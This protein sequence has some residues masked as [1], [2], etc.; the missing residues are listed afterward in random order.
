[1]NVQSLDSKIFSSLLRG[2]AQNLGKHEREVNELNVFPIPDGDTGSNML[3]TVKGGEQTPVG[4]DDDLGVTARRIADGML[5][6]A[7]GNSGVIL[8]QF[9]DGIAAGL[10]GYKV[11]DATILAQAFKKGVEHAYAAVL[12]PT[13]GTILTVAREASAYAADKGQTVPY[14]F[15][16]DFLTQARIT[17]QNTPDML[18]VLKKAGVVD[19]GGAGLIYI[20]EGMANTL[21]GSDNAGEIADYQPVQQHGTIDL[22]RFDENSELTYGYCTEV[23]L[24]LQNAKTDVKNFDEKV[25]KDFLSSVGDSVVC[26][27]SGSVIKLHVHTTQP[28]RVLEF[29]QKFGEYLTVK[30]ENMNL[31]HNS[32]PE[33]DPAPKPAERKAFGVVAVCAGE[34]IKNTFREIGADEIVEGGQSMN[35]SSS[36]FIEAFDRVNAD[37]IFVLP[38]NGNVILAAQQAAKMYGKSDVRVLPS[39]TLG[40]GYAVL[41]ML[42]FDGGNVDEIEKNLTAAMEGV[43]TASVSCCV[44][45]AEMDGFMLHAG[46]YIGHVGKEIFSADNNRRDT[47]LMLCEKLDFTDR[48]ICIILYGKDASAEEA[49]EIADHIRR[50]HRG[51]EVYLIDGGQDIYSY[52]LI[53]E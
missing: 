53:L 26:F 24:R 49:G 6:S 38:N 31:Q 10:D 27:K 44:R 16:S 23:L 37:V 9:F 21:S 40:D 36:D 41:T 1:M 20:I 47:A 28:Y 34:G 11:A 32:L 30:I 46:D 4:E 14:D 45:D 50:A 29:C 13:E 17:L 2:G 48:E 18:P 22:D 33:S 12:E 52:I 5:L 19:S 3:L 8:S 43:T 7:R 42:D 35:P 39:K 15:L 25:I 51:C